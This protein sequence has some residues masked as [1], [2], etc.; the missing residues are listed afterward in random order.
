MVQFR[1]AE[2]AFF[3]P[4]IA[5]VRYPSSVVAILNR[6]APS[7]SLS[8]SLLPFFF[9]LPLWPELRNWWEKRYKAA[10]KITLIGQSFSSFCPP[11]LN[12]HP[13]NSI[14]QNQLRELRPQHALLDSS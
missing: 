4:L 2:T 8:F 12:S 14:F 1:E 6:D 7:A 3:P 11:T 5:A 10:L 9:P 13:P